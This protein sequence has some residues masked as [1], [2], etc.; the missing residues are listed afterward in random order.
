MDKIQALNIVKDILY[1]HF[2]PWHV[3]NEDREKFLEVLDELIQEERWQDW[4]KN[5]RR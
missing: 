2:G 3:D 4:L 5:E 1:D